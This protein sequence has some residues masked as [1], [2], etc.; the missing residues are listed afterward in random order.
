MEDIRNVFISHIH[1]DDDGVARTKDL[2]E[3]QGMAVRNGSI[4]VDKFNNAASEDY[5]KYQ[6]L[7]PRIR[8]ASV[9]AVY[10]SPETKG[11]KWVDWEIE[12]AQ[13]Q[14]KR[15]VGIWAWGEKGCELPEA[16]QRHGDSVVGWSGES[17]VDAINGTSSDWRKADGTLWDY[18]PIKRF[19]CG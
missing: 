11:S 17:I 19:S 10:V 18:R 8:W 5:I 9:L 1:E 14:G 6:L 4:T 3:K 15:V 7:A 13:K 12:Y 2:A 16:L